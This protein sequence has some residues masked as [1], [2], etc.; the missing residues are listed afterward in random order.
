MPYKKILLILTIIVT[1]AGIITGVFKIDI[2]YFHR[3]EAK[4]LRADI[5]E[6][7]GK[8]EQ[9]KLDDYYFF[10]WKRL[11]LIE[12]RYPNETIMPV[13]VREEYKLLQEQLRKMREDKERE[14]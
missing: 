13:T 9:W 1:F 11:A 6:V 2:R 7:A 4:E 12:E 8:L 5:Q 14:G 3:V 10:L